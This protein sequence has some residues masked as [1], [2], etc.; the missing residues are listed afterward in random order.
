MITKSL[1][2]EIIVYAS[3]QRQVSKSFDMLGIKE[4]NGNVIIVGDIEVKSK[5]ISIKVT[6]EKLSFWGIKDQLEILEKMAIFHSV[7]L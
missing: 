2:N 5:N 7:N 3:L 6:P 1:W 4:Y